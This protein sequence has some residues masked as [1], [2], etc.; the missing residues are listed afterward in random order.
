M[1][2]H[3]SPEGMPRRYAGL[4]ER[5]LA[6]LGRD[7]RIKAIWLGGSWARRDAD[8]GSDL[9]LVVATTDDSYAS[10][11]ESA[12]E[13]WERITPTVLLE[14]VPHA[15]NVW[16]SVAPDGARLDIVVEKES[17]LVRSLHRHRLALVDP[18]G[19]SAR[20]PSPPVPT[21]PDPGGV[22]WRL[23]ELF[24]ALCLIEVLVVREDWLLGV[25]GCA[26]MQRTLADL[27]AAANGTAS[28]NGVKHYASR[29]TSQQ[30]AVLERLPAIAATRE[31]V[32][33]GHQAIFEAVVS[34]VPQLAG[35]LGVGWPS[36]LESTA[37][38][39]LE[40]AERRA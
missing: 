24:R 23:K 7:A 36:G 35:A 13:W 21:G 4:L 40:D 38:A 10:F 33:V 5:A 31:A 9:D 1:G 28:T 39:Q 15:P 37:R 25:Q 17:D 11:V 12:R 34:T 14:T 3:P 32:I 30:R 16:Y 20:V 6:V 19:L 18:D 29:L 22:E 27:Y 8:S 26:L 2:P